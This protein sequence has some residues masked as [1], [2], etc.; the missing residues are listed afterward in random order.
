MPLPRA[1]LNQ[2]KRS[3]RVTRPTGRDA[4]LTRREA[5]DIRRFLCSQ[6]PAVRVAALPFLQAGMQPA[7]LLGVVSDKLAA[8]QVGLA[9]E[10][11][12]SGLVTRLRSIPGEGKQLAAQV[13]NRPPGKLQVFVSYRATVLVFALPIEAHQGA[14]S[15]AE[16]LRAAAADVRAEGDDEKA[17]RFDLLA[18]AVAAHGRRKVA[19]V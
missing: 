17:R 1:D 18:A 8:P 19:H 13:K 16:D 10:G 7:E 2:I 5:I 4:L 15:L 3:R 9:E 6:L 12:V 11:L 14:A